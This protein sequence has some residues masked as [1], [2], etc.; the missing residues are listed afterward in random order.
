MSTPARASL[1]AR[2]ASPDLVPHADQSAADC[3]LHRRLSVANNA[4]YS[5]KTAQTLPTI[6]ATEAA[7]KGAALGGAGGSQGGPVDE[8]CRAA[9]PQP[10]PDR[11]RPPLG[12]RSCPDA[13]GRGRA[14]LSAPT[15]GLVDGR[16]AGRAEEAQ[17][18][19]MLAYSFMR[20]MRIGT[21]FCTCR[22]YVYSIH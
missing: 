18:A 13:Q 16:A 12:P 8:G 14:G 6:T 2:F 19:A 10:P 22:M 9:R 5:P 7:A 17:G 15:G 21:Y 4:L 20:L 11:S 1:P 3:S